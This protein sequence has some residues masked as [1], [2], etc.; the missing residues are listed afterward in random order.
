VVEDAFA[1][2]KSWKKVT[3]LCNQK[4]FRFQGGST[5]SYKILINKRSWSGDVG[6]IMKRR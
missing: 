2:V 3:K 1:R 4:L 6:L 5:K